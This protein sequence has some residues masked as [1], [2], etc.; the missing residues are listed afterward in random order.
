MNKKSKFWLLIIG[1]IMFTF[2]FWKQS[3]GIN[4]F[5]FTLFIVVSMNLV[6]PE[7]RKSVY[8]LIIYAGS[9]VSSLSIV[10]HA[11]NL[12]IFVWIMSLF[13][14]QPIVQYPQLKTLFF[15]SFSGLVEYITSFTLLRENIEK[16]GKASKSSKKIFKILRLIAIPIVAVF[17]FYWIYKAAVPEFDKITDTFFGKI[18]KWLY[19]I[20]K[21]ISFEIVFMIIWGFMTI[22]W[23]LYKKVQNNLIAEESKYTDLI[24]RKRGK[25]SFNFSITKGLKPLLKYE[26]LIALILIIA[27]NV[28][29]LIVN[30]LDITTI[31]FGFKYYEGFDLKQFV[32]SGTY[33][34][35]FS[36]LLSMAIMLFFF[37]SNL[38]F[39][40]KNKHLKIA[41]YFWIA[42]NT[43]LLIS[44]IIRNLH[45]IE[46]FALAYLRI[47]L[48]FF[49]LMVIVGLI[50][51]TIKIKDKKSLFYLLKVNSWALY[52]GFVVF[53][54]FDW[55]TIIAKYNLNHYP[56]AFVE[57]SYMLTL[58]EKIYPLIDKNS[59]ILQQDDSLNTYEYFYDPYDVVFN[60]QVNEFVEKYKEK[61]W[62]SWNYKDNVAYKYFIE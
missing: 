4:S 61:T 46:H 6:F 5:I 44:V 11:S 43:I 28:L 29:L 49:L 51:L 34:L 37:R 62:L 26:N 27:V 41:S 38:N 19:N 53:A 57:A 58:D 16:T 21:N 33:L 39:Y 32:H 20:F 55:D 23:F 35:I 25:E 7:S 8:A 59:Q 60:S 47:G 1:T 36:I 45:Y 17:V 24:E 48:F 9:V 2:I 31:W 12:S 3:I 14:M 40:S 54:V 50:T 56:E 52:I 13:F 42:Q 30:Y 15:A 18:D 22:G 10:Y